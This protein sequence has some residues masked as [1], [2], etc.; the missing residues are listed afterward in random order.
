VE[1]EPGIDVNRSPERRDA[2][3]M[4]RTYPHGVPCWIDTEPED[5][6]AARDFYGGLFGWTFEDAMAPEASGSYLIG[7][8]AGAVVAAIGRVG[9]DSVPGWNTYIAVDD[10]DAV[11]AAV[12]RAGGRSTSSP[13]DAGPAGRSASFT[14]PAGAR[15]RVW[16]PGRRGG[17]DVANAPGTWNFS[18]LH[19]SDPAGAISFYGGLFGW[20][21]DDLGFATLIRRPGYGDHLE[22]TV[23][24]DIRTRQAGVTPPGYEDAVAWLAPAAAGEAPH[25]HVTFA[26]ADRDDAVAT[27][28]ALGAVDLSGPVDTEWTK[29]ATVRE[30]QGAV[31]TLSQYAPAGA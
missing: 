26:V 8:L 10:A 11:A 30:P 25:W 16:Q 21:A 1:R 2:V 13:A 28:L 12:E 20:E 3:T 24:P 19:T 22:A 5:A 15:F 6:D 18:D 29:V 4:S 31:F 23:D 27:A 17:V 7:S 9:A 14:D